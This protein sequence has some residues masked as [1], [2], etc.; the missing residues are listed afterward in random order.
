MDNWPTRHSGTSTQT[1]Q[2]R[3]WLRPPIKQTQIF[4]TAPDPTESYCNRSCLRDP[5]GL[6]DRFCPDRSSRMGTSKAHSGRET[7]LWVLGVLHLPGCPEPWGR[8]G[9]SKPQETSTS[10]RGS[11][12]AYIWQ[13]QRL[14]PPRTQ[15]Y[16]QTRK[17]NVSGQQR[18]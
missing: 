7:H 6:R 17:Q 14:Q 10:P 4:T 1:L 15:L 5:A 2:Y 9:V 8:G 16:S 18:K 11:N 13:G 3:L 12:Q